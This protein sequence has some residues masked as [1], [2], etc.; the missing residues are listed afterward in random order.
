M[1]G[2]GLLGGHGLAQGVV[3][4][5]G[6]QREGVVHVEEHP[7]PATAGGV[8]PPVANVAVRPVGIGGVDFGN[9]V[10]DELIDVHLGLDVG[11]D[12][13]VGGVVA[14]DVVVKLV[15]A[16]DGAGHG[17]Q[18]VVDGVEV[19]FLVQPVVVLDEGLVHLFA[20]A[21]DTPELAV[22][23][24]QGRAIGL[25]VDVHAIDEQLLAEDVAQQAL[26]VLAAGAQQQPPV[27]VE[28]LVAKEGVAEVVVAIDLARLQ[29]E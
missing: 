29:L 17:R 4:G 24:D 18:I 19:G 10:V 9:L 25:A 13:R 15:P 28:R 11:V 8:G 16:G 20:Q 5:T 21:V 27:G 6:V 1:V 26:G 3:A 22:D 14:G 2:V 7:A 12:G 23:V